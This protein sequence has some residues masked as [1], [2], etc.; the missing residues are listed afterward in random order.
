MSELTLETPRIIM[1]TFRDSDAEAAHGYCG[2][3]ENV[4][5][6]LKSA[7]TL[8]QCR[9]FVR[10]ARE[11][12][13]AEPRTEFHF[14]LEPKFSESCAI[15]GTGS[16]SL[17]NDQG[18]LNWVIHRDYWGQG[19]CTEV[20]RALLELAFRRLG[21]RRVTAHCDAENIASWR[22]MEKLGMRREATF[23][24]GRVAYDRAPDVHG[25]E[26]AYAILAREFH[27]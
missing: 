20:G 17:D 22:V 1:R 25:D 12:A 5:Y 13:M 15:I 16:L 18:E 6:L 19:L 14:A 27:G 9:D 10:F 26:Y 21:L 7:K 11:S 2:N 4:K 23:I 3:E 8:A 24:E